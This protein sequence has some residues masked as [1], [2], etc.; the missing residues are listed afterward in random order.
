MSEQTEM[1]LGSLGEPAKDRGDVPDFL[2]PKKTMQIAVSGGVLVTDLERRIIDTPDFQRLRGI[3][4]LGLAYFVYPTALHTRFDHSL[5]T[6]HM[7]TRMVHA[8]REN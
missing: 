5:G 8:I 1:P 4:Q 6:L 2:R 3:R 7:A